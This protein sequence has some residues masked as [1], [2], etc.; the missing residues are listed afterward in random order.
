MEP[1]TQNPT[2]SDPS[3]TSSEQEG[4]KLERAV[5]ATLSKE[6]LIEQQIQL[7]RR[8]QEAELRLNAQE[9]KSQS[10]KPL[11]EYYAK[12][13][14][15]PGGST[16][17]TAASDQAV[18]DFVNEHYKPEDLPSLLAD[19]LTREQKLFV[20]NQ[21]LRAENEAL[22]AQLAIPI[23][24]PTAQPKGEPSLAK[25]MSASLYALQLLQDLDL[26]S[27]DAAL[28]KKPATPLNLGKDTPKV[29]TASVDK[30]LSSF[31]DYCN[32]NITCLK[33]RA[34][35]A[36][37]AL[38]Q[39][40]NAGHFSELTGLFR[41]DFTAFVRDLEKT[42]Q[43]LQLFFSSLAEADASLGCGVN[44]MNILRQIA[45][46]MSPPEDVKLDEP[47]KRQTAFQLAEDAIDTACSKK[48]FLDARLLLNY[49]PAYAKKAAK[50]AGQEAPDQKQRQ[51]LYYHAIQCFMEKLQNAPQWSPVLFL[52]YT[53]T[54][55]A[56]ADAAGD[57]KDKCL[58]LISGR[59]KALLVALPKEVD[60]DSAEAINK[61]IY[62]GCIEQVELRLPLLKQ[63]KTILFG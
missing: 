12:E 58:E 39:F 49:I 55:I 1:V 4:E 34:A 52:H 7:M 33:H 26:K 22:K 45:T 20:E 40:W 9:R 62:R 56:W 15:A 50:A 31:T 51:L 30:L 19:A 27:A 5:Y 17:P 32:A 46:L 11:K 43:E 2:F 25:D 21:E 41:E 48:E 37:I 54:L 63:L 10:K 29:P 47:I 23:A 28:L 53:E 36:S 60:K 14:A 44:P 3:L 57:K 35:V 6:E 24:S 13:G 16:K 42:P 18:I 38:Q 59:L 8:L 61:D